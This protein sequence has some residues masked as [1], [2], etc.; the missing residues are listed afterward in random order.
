MFGWLSKKTPGQFCLRSDHHH[1]VLE[2]CDA[3]LNTVEMLGEAHFE[4]LDEVALFAWLKKFPQLKKAHLILLLSDEACQWFERF[5]EEWAGDFSEIVEDADFFYY[6]A[7]D[8][9]ETWKIVALEQASVEAYLTV[10]KQLQ[11]QTIDIVPTTYPEI[12]FL[13][14]RA[15][16]TKQADYKKWFVLGLP[17]L[18]LLLCWGFVHI[19]TTE[20][21]RLEKRN[22]FLQHSLVKLHASQSGVRLDGVLPV[23]KQLL[24]MPE[25]LEMLQLAKNHE[26]ELSGHAKNMQDLNSLLNQLALMPGVNAKSLQGLQIQGQNQ[27]IQNWKI[28]FQLEIH[29]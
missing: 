21:K 8:R 27:G 15:Y 22:L 17:I 11:L 23:V 25:N 26:G 4:M 14:K 3:S 28:N 16:Q 7:F 9:G 1:L 6:R 20:L 19:K 24:A 29:S 13:P 18:V 12:H 5:K 2:K 10:A